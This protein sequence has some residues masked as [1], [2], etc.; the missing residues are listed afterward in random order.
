MAIRG[1]LAQAVA[2]ML[3]LLA[4]GPVLAATP[5]AD[6]F[7]QRAVMTAAGNSP[8]VRAGHRHRAEQAER[9][10]PAAQR[11]ARAASRP[12]W[13]R[14]RRKQ[15]TPPARPTPV[16]R[17]R[18]LAAQQVTPPS[19]TT[20]GSATWFPGEFATWLAE[21]PPVGTRGPR[22]HVS[23]RDRFGWDVMLFVQALHA[24]RADTLTAVANFADSAQPLRRAPG[25]A[26]RGHRQQPL[27]RCA[28]RADIDSHTPIDARHHC[29]ARPAGC[30]RPT[31]WRRRER[32]AAAVGHPHRLVVPVPASRDRRRASIRARRW[33]SNSESAGDDGERRA[34]SLRRGRRLHRR[35]GVGRDRPAP[36][37]RYRPCGLKAMMLSPT[38]SR[39]AVVQRRRFG[40][41]PRRGRSSTGR[42][43]G[44]GG[45]FAQQHAPDRHHPAM[46][47]GEGAHQR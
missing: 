26:R 18:R 34:H 25:A 22:W 12:G 43:T 33:R 16:R 1:R 40:R 36:A 21:Q 35:A 19:P 10:R 39:G 6:L 37:P 11:C 28:R 7:Y 41:R 46:Q 27:S 30:S 32:A 13:Q 9:H 5:A 20:P 44:Y 45:A 4:V 38:A 24:G 8:A 17:Y 2:A 42:R 3:G 14:S 23:Q 47:L 31:R 15:R 29:R